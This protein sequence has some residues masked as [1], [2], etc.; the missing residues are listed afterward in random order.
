[1]E[2]GRSM[3]EGRGAEEGRG[4]YG[5]GEGTVQ[6]WCGRLTS[7]SAMALISS[8]QLIRVSLLL[9]E[10]LEMLIR[11]HITCVVRV[12]VDGPTVLHYTPNTVALNCC[13]AR[14]HARTHTHTHLF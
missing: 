6:R 4:Q 1:M 10:A 14:T 13:K 8:S 12:L 5:G 3:K 2:E 11:T 7:I 9:P